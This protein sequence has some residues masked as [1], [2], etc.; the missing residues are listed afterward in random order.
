MQNKALTFSVSAF[1]LL[2]F[3]RTFTNKNLLDK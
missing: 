3:F 2:S 1:S